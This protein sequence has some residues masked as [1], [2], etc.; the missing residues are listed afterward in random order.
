KGVPTGANSKFVRELVCLIDP[1]LRKIVNIGAQ[2][3]KAGDLDLSYGTNDV[4]SR[5]RLGSEDGCDADKSRLAIKLRQRYIES[6]PCIQKKR[7]G[8]KLIARYQKVAVSDLGKGKPCP[9]N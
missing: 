8:R 7:C 2:R 6:R 4:F 1:V 5:L 3:T 9:S